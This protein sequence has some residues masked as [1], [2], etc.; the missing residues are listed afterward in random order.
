MFHGAEEAP[1]I[2]PDAKPAA[3]PQPR[4]VTMYVPRDHHCGSVLRESTVHSQ[5]QGTFPIPPPP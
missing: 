2:T 3:E 5:G 1:A 4:G